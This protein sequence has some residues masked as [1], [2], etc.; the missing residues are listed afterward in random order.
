TDDGR[1][2]VCRGSQEKYG[3]IRRRTGS[4]NTRLGV[5]F[6]D[7]GSDMHHVLYISD[8]FLTR[9][10]H[11][12]QPLP[13][14]AASGRKACRYLAGLFSDLSP[15]SSRTRSWRAKARAV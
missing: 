12:R 3:G 7:G 1:H 13:I 10:L 11:I 4:E 14:L 6:G 8:E 2:D 5:H 9:V 15:V